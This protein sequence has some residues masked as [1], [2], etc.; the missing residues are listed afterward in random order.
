MDA[1]SLALQC[2]PDSR[3]LRALKLYQEQGNK[4]RHMYGSTYRVP[5]QDGE[6]AYEVEYG[7]HEYCSCRDNRY[8][9]INCVHIYALAIATAKGSIRHPQLAAGDPFVAAGQRRLHACN[10]GWVSL[11]VEV[12]G[13]ERVELVRCRRCA[14][15][16]QT[17]PETS[18]CAALPPVPNVFKQQYPA[19]CSD[20]ACGRCFPY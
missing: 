1:T 2:S 14:A 8:R 20:P 10:D 12:D 7:R 13:Q 17:L 5:S 4:I 11:G 15:G 6:R 3:E 19:Y 18:L 16:N 9:N